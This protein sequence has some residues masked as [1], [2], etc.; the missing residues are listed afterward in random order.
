MIASSNEKT[1]RSR[2]ATMVPPVPAPRMTIRCMGSLSPPQPDAPD[3]GRPRAEGQMVGARRR[4]LRDGAARVQVLAQ[5][6]GLVE[7]RLEVVGLGAEG[8]D[9][10]AD[11]GATVDER[12]GGELLVVCLYHGHNP[13][14]KQIEVLLVLDPLGSVPETADRER[15]R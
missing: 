8:D 2:L 1:R 15:R 3:R 10:G 4:G 7:H 9:A 6:P 11:R 13:H 5:R 14:V 12:V